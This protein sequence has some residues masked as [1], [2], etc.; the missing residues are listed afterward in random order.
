MRYLLL[1]LIVFF[2]GFMRYFLSSFCGRLFLKLGKILIL[3][4]FLVWTCAW[5]GFC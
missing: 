3:G 4:S 5:H 2:G 1:I